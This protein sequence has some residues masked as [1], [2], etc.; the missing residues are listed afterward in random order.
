VFEDLPY[1]LQ[2]KF[3]WLENG[4]FVF[5]SSSVV[6]L[7]QKHYMLKTHDRLFISPSIVF[8]DFLDMK[9]IISIYFIHEESKKS[10]VDYR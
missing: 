8:F 5:L 10:T 9:P 3:S 6:G 7:T 1:K 4:F 2:E